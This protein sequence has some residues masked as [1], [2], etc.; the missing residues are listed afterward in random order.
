MLTM[1]EDKKKVAISSARLSDE[2]HYLCTMQN[3]AGTASLTT[4][5]NVGV[6][7]QIIE[8]PKTEVVKKGDTVTLWWTHHF[9]QNINRIMQV[10]SDWK[11]NA[12]YKL[13]E[14][15]RNLDK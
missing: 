7:P 14:G 15:R 5:L 8:R 9:L 6:P 10:R 4:A 12:C 2:G 13:E 1:S 11:S 3:E